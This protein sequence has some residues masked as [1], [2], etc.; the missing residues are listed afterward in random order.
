MRAPG[1]RIGSF[2]RTDA[3]RESK[4]IVVSLPKNSL[5]VEQSCVVFMSRSEE[6]KGG[7]PCRISVGRVVHVCVPCDAGLLTNTIL[8]ATDCNRD[9]F[10]VYCRLFNTAASLPSAAHH[11]RVRPTS[12]ASGDRCTLLRCWS[13]GWSSTRR[14]PS[15]STPTWTQSWPRTLALER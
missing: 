14:T 3:R 10:L 4:V 9:Y 5:I 7:W 12:P 11:H 2:V 15:R 1:V 13:K 8:I 6:T